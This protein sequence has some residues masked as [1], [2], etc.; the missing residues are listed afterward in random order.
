M[1]GRLK[2]G[3][4]AAAAAAA[5]ASLVVAVAVLVGVVAAAGVMAA[6]VVAVL[7]AAVAVVGVAATVAVAA[8]VVFLADGSL[9]SVGDGNGGTIFKAPPAVDTT[10]VGTG[11]SL[12]D[13]AG[14]GFTGVAAVVLSTSPTTAAVVVLAPVVPVA[15]L[16]PVEA[17][18]ASVDATLFGTTSFGRTEGAS[19]CTDRL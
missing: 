6:V 13:D 7:A 12:L 3:N 10:L 1:Y 18:A 8:V 4:F 9:K 5:A 16:T 17:P 14:F 15:V 11:T 19:L 2:E